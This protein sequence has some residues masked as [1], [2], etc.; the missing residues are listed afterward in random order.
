MASISRDESNGK[1]ARKGC[2]PSGAS[3]F[4]PR[5]GYFADTAQSP[6]PK[7]H[8]PR[9][10]LRSNSVGIRPGG[11]GAERCRNSCS[12]ASSDSRRSGRSLQAFSSF[13][14]SFPEPGSPG[15]SLIVRSTFS[16]P[17]RVV[18]GGLDAEKVLVP[19]LG[20]FRRLIAWMPGRRIELREAVSHEKFC[21]TPCVGVEAL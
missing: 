11:C 4:C 9:P 10:S 21:R 5:D 2:A 19:R 3:A 17:V 13:L 8:Q 1:Q 16:P 7:R 12:F 20:L 14:Q 15:A 18:Q 6:P